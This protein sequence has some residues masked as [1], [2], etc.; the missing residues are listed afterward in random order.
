MYVCI[1][2]AVTDREIRELAGEGVGTLRQLRE[3]TGCAGTCGQCAP[4]ARAILRAAS[5]CADSGGGGDANQIP[6]FV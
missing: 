4:E 2:N 3:Q 1:C 5:P 6:A